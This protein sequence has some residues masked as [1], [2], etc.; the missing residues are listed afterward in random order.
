MLKIKTNMDKPKV[1]RGA[2]PGQEKSMTRW[3]A[4]EDRK[5]LEGIKTLSV[6]EISKNHQRSVG[7]ICSRLAVIAVKLIDEGKSY[8][9]AIA[10]TKAS[11]I[12]IDKQIG[13]NKAKEKINSNIAT[14][15]N[16]MLLLLVTIVLLV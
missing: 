5:L 8:D 10:I 6:D 13:R 15:I 11:R 7:A 9:E 14:V 2:K 3:T 12:D 1:K 4:E 16:P